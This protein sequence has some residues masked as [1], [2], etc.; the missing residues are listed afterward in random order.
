MACFTCHSWGT[1][2]VFKSLSRAAAKAA[3]S[4]LR[5]MG[6]LPVALNW[7]ARAIQCE[8]C[9]MRVIERGV[10]YCGRPYLRRIARDSENEGCGC[11]TREKAKSPTEH[12]PLTI[13]GRSA[14]YVNG[15][16]NCKWC[17]LQ[18]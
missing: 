7:S 3:S 1:S 14:G 8:R 16:C 6:A 4:K 9:P 10:S 5:N 2:T 17:N 11:P 13:N 18:K 15:K 12:C